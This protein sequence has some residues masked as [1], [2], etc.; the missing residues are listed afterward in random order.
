M[1]K[2]HPHTHYNDEKEDLEMIQTISPALDAEPL[3]ESIL[4]SP[5][6]Q[7]Y[8]WERMQK[9]LSQPDQAFIVKNNLIF[10]PE[11]INHIPGFFFLYSA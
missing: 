6:W 5:G 11:E 1:P 2:G 8:T 3:I 10:S 9:R 7:T 4:I